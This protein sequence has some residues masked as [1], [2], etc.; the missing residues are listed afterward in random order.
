MVTAMVNNNSALYGGSQTI[1]EPS[2][3]VL[4]QAGLLPQGRVLDLA[5]GRGRHARWLAA[6]GWPVLAVDRDAQ[7]LA[8]L[9]DLPG[10]ETRCCDLEGERWP[11]AGQVFAGVV[12]TNYLFRPRLPSLAAMLRPGAVLIYETFMLGQ[13]RFGRPSNPEFL[14][15]PDELY[16]WAI[17]CGLDVLAFEQGEQSVPRP[18]C[19]QRL[20]ARRPSLG[21]VI[22]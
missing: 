9:A 17:E 6:N 14:L 20:C 12:V 13:A 22:I 5:C 16:R 1:G 18:A 8:G 11:L 7:A 3:W 4:A 19:M 21:T 2:P 10:V 15:A